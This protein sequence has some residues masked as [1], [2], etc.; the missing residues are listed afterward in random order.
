MTILRIL[1][2]S[3]IAAFAAIPATTSV[4]AFPAAAL[5]QGASDLGTVTEV[6]HRGRTHRMARYHRRQRI[7]VYPGGYAEPYANSYFG[8]YRGFEDPG[9]A[10]HGNIPGCVEDLGYG[11]WESCDR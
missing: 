9:F 5:E 6:R 11:R 4:Q 8:L 2:L 3:G 7:V 10:Y 1:A